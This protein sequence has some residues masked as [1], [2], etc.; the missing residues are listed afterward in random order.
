MVILINSWAT[1][2]E[3]QLVLCEPLQSAHT[4]THNAVHSEEKR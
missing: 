3:T 1:L 2:G 4:H